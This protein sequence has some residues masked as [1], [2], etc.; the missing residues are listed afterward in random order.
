VTEAFHEFDEG[1]DDEEPGLLLPPDDRVWRHPSELSAHPTASMAAEVSA[2]RE[3]WLS[4]TPTRAGAWSAGLVGAVLATG[5]VLVGTH[6]TV[7]LGK[8]SHP[9]APIDAVATTLV[10]PG[11]SEVISPGMDKIAATVRAGLTVVHVSKS[12]GSVTG[13]GVVMASDGK[14]LVPLELVLGGSA[15]AVT[16]SDGAV[17]AGR[18][19]GTDEATQLAVVSI[20]ISGVSNAAFA[21]LAASRTVVVPGGWLGVEWSGVSGTAE[22]D[23]VLSI[24]S[25][26]SVGE[27]SAGGAYQLLDAVHLQ[28]RD[29]ASAPIGSVLVSNTAELLG[30]VTARTGDD[31]VEVPG[32]LAELVGQQIV[33]HGRVIHGWLGIEGKTTSPLSSPQVTSDVMPAHELRLPPGVE[34]LEVDAGTPAS[35]A[36]LRAGDV[37]EAVDG[38]V[39]NSMQQLQDMLYVMPPHTDVAL[40]IQRGSSVST[41]EAFLQ[42][43]A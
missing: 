43:A 24:G 12:G 33:E 14:I 30:I 40:T 26:S 23:S 32:P 42:P 34:I 18:I 5:V 21:P 22:I 3:R 4:R 27:T 9:A 35:L 37:I 17:Y 10:R 2:A 7:W 15:I 8:P 16:T 31:V 20:G 13:N 11:V 39:I 41:V 1:F 6:L 28:A 25:V 19:I 29:L 36:G 38:Q